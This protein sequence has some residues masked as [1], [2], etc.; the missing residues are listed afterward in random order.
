DA[1]TIQQEF[2]GIFPSC[3]VTR[4]MMNLLEYVSNFKQRLTRA[5]EL[6]KENLALTQTQMK[7]WYDKDAHAIYHD[8]DVGDAPPVKQHPYRVNPLKEE[9]LKKEIQYMLDNDII[10]PSRSEWSSPC[11]LVPKPDKTYRF[12]TDFRK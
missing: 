10:E 11:V 12:C 3:A 5:C 2:P 7:T 8:V 1:E 4:S 6:A 9:H